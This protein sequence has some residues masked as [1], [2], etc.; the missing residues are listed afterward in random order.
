M[1]EFD[2]QLI[3]KVQE[4]PCLFNTRSSD[5]KVSIK[6]ENA[7]IVIAKHMSI[8]G[9]KFR[10]ITRLTDRLLKYVYLI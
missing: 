7:W 10:S 5:F 8:F 9:E 6:K 3:Y 1:A 4:Y 2:E